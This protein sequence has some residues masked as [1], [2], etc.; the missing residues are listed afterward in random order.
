M[1]QILLYFWQLCLLKQSPDQLPRGNFVLAFVIVTYL[2][3]ALIAVTLSR[4][5]YGSFEILGSV[6]IGML[7][8]ALVTFLLLTFKRVEA[9]FNTTYA[10]LLGANALMLII[11]IPVNLLLLNVENTSLI[12]LA[13][14][15]S[16]VCLGWWLAIAGFIYHKATDISLLQGS[17]IAFVSELLGVMLAITLFPTN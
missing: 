7:L 14:S 10:A 15:V 4:P 6:T 16:W 5:S 13:D 2:I 12:L 8:Q 17:A 11:L 3:I 1:Q 9:R